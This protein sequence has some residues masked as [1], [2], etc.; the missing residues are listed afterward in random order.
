MKAAQHKN[1]NMNW[2]RF[3]PFHLAAHKNR[4]EICDF[5][6][7][8]IRDKHPRNFIGDTTLHLTAEK[9]H[10]KVCMLILQGVKS[11]NPRNHIGKTPLTVARENNQFKVC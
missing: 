7:K 11:K 4:V 8:T 2:T 10:V 6:M 5:L 1:P 9:G 3:P